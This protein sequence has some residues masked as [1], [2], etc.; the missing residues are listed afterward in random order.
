MTKIL[1][2]DDDEAIS[3]IYQATFQKA[4]FEVV[5]AYDGQSGVEKAKA[6]HPDLILLDQVMPDI[7]GTDVLKI[8]RGD[9]STQSIP[10]ALLSNF[11]QAEIVKDA[12]SQ[13]AID[14]ILKYQIEPEDLVGKVKRILQEV[15]TTSGSS[16][17][18]NSGTNTGTGAP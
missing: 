16:G 12:I 17:A 8:L 4:A 10:I 13:G 14:Y 6:E 1:I 7:K 11:G 9:P 5:T 3:S 15:K 18:P 2:I